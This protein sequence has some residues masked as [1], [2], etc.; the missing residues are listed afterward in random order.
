MLQRSL[1]ALAKRTPGYVFWRQNTLV[2]LENAKRNYLM[3]ERPVPIAEVARRMVRVK[4]R[5]EATGDFHEKNLLR[6]EYKFFSGKLCD[7]RAARATDMIAFLQCAAFFGFWDTS[8]I[9]RVM[10]ELL[11]KIA[12][13]T[14]NELVC[15]FVTLPGLRKQQSE[16]TGRAAA[17][18][19]RVVPDLT[20]QECLAAC[21]VCD[22]ATP[23]ALLRGLLSAIEAE[24]AS[25]CPAQMV[26]V[27]DT[28]SVAPPAVQREFAGLWDAIKAR[29]V[30]CSNELGCMDVAVLYTTLQAGADCDAASAQKLLG[31]F[32]AQAPTGACARST[33]MMFSATAAASLTASLQFAQLMEVR[34][35][36]LS[37]D[38]TPAELLAVFKVY[39]GCLVAMTALVEGHAAAAAG[40][41]QQQQPLSTPLAAELREAL[42]RQAAFRH[43][44]AELNEQLVALLQ[45]AG[46]HVSTAEQLDLLDAYATAVADLAAAGEGRDGAWAA[47][48]LLRQLPLTRDVMRVLADKL[49]SKARGAPT[50]QLMRLLELA[51]DLGPAILPDAI[52]AAAVQEL[53]VREWALSGDEAAELTG[54]LAGLT[55]LRAEHQRK[56][57]LALVPK[58]RSFL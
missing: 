36:F 1:L 16:L 22:E 2:E 46:A 35:V 37:T 27:M 25:L 47:S 29:T 41:R 53:A 43:V 55:G 15:L 42:Q 40:G 52:V 14:P 31:R 24:A 45:G 39:L 33:A 44:V 57:N 6:G 54:F 49:I 58:I 13:L 51:N 17:R 38:F 10:A 50:P 7:V 34:V 3:S 4:A 11:L 9:E 5:Y 18:L 30:G 32:V 21:A 20:L 12:E 19:A 28:H 8:Q 23:A 26:E 56:I 48:A